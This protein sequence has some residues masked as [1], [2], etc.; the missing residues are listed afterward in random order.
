[1]MK[2]PRSSGKIRC[3]DIAWAEMPVDGK[4]A[5]ITEKLFEL[6]NCENLI[7]LALG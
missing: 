2:G 4:V 5:S 7:G 3:G 6:W 1:M